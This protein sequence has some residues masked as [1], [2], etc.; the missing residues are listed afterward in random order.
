VQKNFGFIA[1]LL[2]LTSC[3]NKSYVPTMY[4]PML[5]SQKRE[6]RV[7]YAQAS[8]T[9]KAQLAYALNK[10]LGIA[11]NETFAKG[12][13]NSELGI[14]Y[15]RNREYSYYEFG[16]GIGYQANYI[17]YNYRPGAGIW[18]FSSKYFMESFNCQYGSL[19]VSGCALWGGDDV[20]IGFGFKGGPLYIS[21]YD[22]TLD[23]DPYLGKDHPHPLD[24]EK[25]KFNNALTAIFEPSIVLASSTSESISFRAQLGYTYI[26]G[27]YQH[28]YYFYQSGYGILS[29]SRVHPDHNSITFSIGFS[30][31]L[32]EGRPS[33]D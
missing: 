18:L 21:H 29:G 3:V 22:Y 19:F 17:N 26:P 11:F 16:G 8:S 13:T 32:F 31:K 1:L 23:V 24:H 4:E 9:G 12:I 20:K 6:L 28:D 27:A 7:S 25:F 5:L 14:S 15:F 2:V 33:E 10:N 30:F